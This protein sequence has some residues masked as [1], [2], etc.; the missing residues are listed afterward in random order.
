MVEVAAIMIMMM[1]VMAHD[2]DGDGDGDGGVHNVACSVCCV[3]LVEPTG[4]CGWSKLLYGSRYM[5]TSRPMNADSVVAS[6]LRL[7]P[8][9]FL[10]R[11]AMG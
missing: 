4:E 3:S 11:L 5:L 9:G 8:R 6:A 10:H 2:D 7:C 1:S